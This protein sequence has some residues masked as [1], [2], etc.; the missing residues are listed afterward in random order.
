MPSEPGRT[1]EVERTAE[2]FA[3]KRIAPTASDVDHRDPAFPAEA[4]RHGVEA[5]F[6]RFVLPEAAG[7]YGFEL[8]ELCALVGTLARTCAGHAMVF[9]VH[10]AVVRA[11]HDTFA[12]GSRDGLDRT[13]ERSLERILASGQPIGAAIPEPAG[14]GDFEAVLTADPGERGGM[15][16]HGA[17]TPAINGDPSGWFVLFARCADGKPVA[18]L[19]QGGEERLGLGVPEAVLGL[20]AMPV[21]LLE[22]DH[23]PV[24]RERTLA[25][26]EGALRLYRTLLGRLSLVTTAASS[27]LMERAYRKA[28]VYA[29]E[30]YQGAKMIIDHSHI[31]ILLGG[32]AAGARASAH[33]VAGAA[34]GPDDLTALLGVKVAVTEQAVRVCTDAVQILGGYGYMRD[35]GLEKAMRD[36][37]VLALLP[38]SNPRAELLIAALEKERIG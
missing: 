23:L 32:M 2:A 10:A 5:G 29:G 31:R 13:L 24:S 34:A 4:F 9:G 7:G 1:G 35:Y 25:E 14:G 12:S 22:P 18:L 36:A 26:G 33:A 27:G 15:R 28:I 16:I 3:A 37:A 19:V 30:R 6:D 17:A 38:V 21:V 11:L 20:T 8:P